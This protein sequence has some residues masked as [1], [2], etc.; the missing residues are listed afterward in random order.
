MNYAEARQLADG[1]GWHFTVRNDDRIWAASCCRTQIPATAEDVAASDWIY[2]GSLKVG[3]LIDGLP[4]EPHPTREAAE[5]CFNEW[6]RLQPIELVDDLYPRW[7][8]CE[9]DDW[10]EPCGEP[11]KGGAWHHDYAHKREYALCP[12]HRTVDCVL[13]LIV[14]VTSVTHS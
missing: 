11:T 9:G 10:G 14:D 5:R 12:E 4:H 3:D 8:D 13:S 7:H 2:H 1:S 6:R